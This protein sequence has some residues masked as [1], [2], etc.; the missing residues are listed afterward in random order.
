MLNVLRPEAGETLAIFG[1][2]G[3]GLAAVIAAVNLTGARVLV[4]DINQGRLDL[5]T[6]LGAHHTINGRETDAVAGLLDLTGGRGADATLEATGVPP[7]LQQAIR[8]LAPLGRC[9]VVGA[10]PPTVDGAFNVLDSI[11]KGTRII[12][13]NQGDALPRNAIP[14][15]TD[16]YLKGRFPF[17]KLVRFYPFEDIEQA[18]ADAH[19]GSTIKPVLRMLGS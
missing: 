18:A 17:D 9:G 6:E 13:I 11:V 16:L 4:V 8:S 3:V 1:A 7:V 10:P 2:G 12:G 19:D 14:A 15:L 5:A